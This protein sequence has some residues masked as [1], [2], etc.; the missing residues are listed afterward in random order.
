MA[1]FGEALR[2]FAAKV[3]RR[4][5]Q[6][7][8]GSVESVKTSVVDGS[9]LTAAPGQPVDTGHLRDSWQVTYPEDW[10]GE[11]ATNVGYAIAIEDGYVHEHV[12][13][14]YTR[15]DGTPVRQHTVRGHPQGLLSP[16]GGFHSVALTRSNWDRIVQDETRKA[17]S[18]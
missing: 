18:T 2:L 8:V 7:F 9:P 4:S 13:G 3:E 11:V 10:V 17:R 14:P 16:V 12:R 15:A 5:R 6:V 1:G